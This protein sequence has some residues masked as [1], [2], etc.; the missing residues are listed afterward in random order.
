MNKSILYPLW[1]GQY[2]VVLAFWLWNHIDNPNGNQLTQ[3][4]GTLLLSLGQLAALLAVMGIL[5]QLI[6]IGRVKW[7]ER[8]FGLDRLSRIHHFDGLVLVV[9]LIAH[10]LLVGAGYAIQS[11][12]SLWSQLVDFILHWE[13]VLA[14][15]IGL[16]I[17]LTV[18]FFSIGFIRKHLKYETWYYIHLSLYP[19][20][21]LAIVHQFEIGGD[22]TANRAFHAYW[23][24]IYLF[25]AGNLI[26]FRFVMPAIHYY[27]QR[28]VVDH[29]TP[30]TSETTSVYIHG[31]DLKRFPIRAGQFMIV[32]F[33]A[34]GFWAQA[35]PF[36]MSCFPEGSQIRL[37]IK[38]SGD[39]TARIPALLPGTPV[40]I[41]GP[42]GIFTADRCT[43][44]K[45]L[46]IAGGIGITP[47]RSLAEE[48]TGSGKNSVLL[49]SNRMMNTLVFDQELSELASSH[50]NLRV[51]KIITN[52]PDWK[53]QTGRL[54]RP[55]LET[56][57]PDLAERD[58][59]LCG[60]PAM[61]ACIISAL[62]ELG[63]SRTRIH[64]EKFSF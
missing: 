20:V 9:L 51:V 62:K 27:R 41:D 23:I 60:P 24:A 26:L 8:T 4:T 5:V 33:L 3:D 48:F 2:G 17:I 54:D 43:S 53:G 40:L 21:I 52:D 37:S 31:N 39:F 15:A 18:A 25:A 49:Y 13:D 45:V 28:F 58:V 22:L 1:L 36:S 7:V 30:E 42:H 35:H 29:L 47:I 63:I 59:Y 56:L 57:V 19:A 44:D 61:M 16:L 32:R 10:P 34:R 38:N 14:A 46:M 64:Y 50:S 55:K 11:N 6:L 12:V